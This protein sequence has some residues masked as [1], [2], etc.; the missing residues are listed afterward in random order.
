MYGLQATPTRTQSQTFYV[1]PRLKRCTHVFLRCDRI[2]KPLQ[3]PY[4]GPFKVLNR[5]DKT[6][7]ILLNGK[8]EVVSID[9][10]KAAFVE[11]TSKDSQNKPVTQEPT[12][13]TPTNTVTPISPL[14]SPNSPPSTDGDL[15]HDKPSS[16]S[17]TT[18]NGHRV[19]FPKR[20]VSYHHF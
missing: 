8:E 18:L 10:L 2:R 7:T 13:M 11:D 20:F 9:R 14:P 5:S 6:F 15:S 4:D 12:T 19:R 1:D 3:P 17:V 16:T